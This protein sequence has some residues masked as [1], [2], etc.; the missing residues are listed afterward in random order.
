MIKNTRL[1]K[2]DFKFNFISD[3]GVQYICDVLEKATHVSGV[4]IP[5]RISKETL[6]MYKERIFNNKPKKGKG[7][8]KGKKPKKK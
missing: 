3:Y 6:E 2:Y 1:E 7:S 8:K 4:E 5:D